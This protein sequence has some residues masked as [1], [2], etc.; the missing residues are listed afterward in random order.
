MKSV[1]KERVQ[2]LSKIKNIS[3]ILKTKDLPFSIPLKPG[4]PLLAFQLL[5]KYISKTSISDSDLVLEF[6]PKVL[7]F[8]N[9]VEL[10]ESLTKVE[11]PSIADSNQALS[12]II[13]ENLINAL[14]VKLS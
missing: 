14:L 9:Y 13:D 4:L 5:S 10:Q 1:T 3:D 8:L 7:G 2:T 11:H 12:L 6:S